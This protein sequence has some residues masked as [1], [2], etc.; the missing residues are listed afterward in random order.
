MFCPRCGTEN[1]SEPSYCRTCGQALSSVR[2]AV[3]GHVDQAIK[4]LRN[5]QRISVYRIRLAVSA[6]LILAALATLFTGGRVGFANIGSATVLLIII[7]IFF[8]QLVLKSRRVARLLDP[9]AERGELGTSPV[10][11]SLSEARTNA[12]PAPVHK[13]PLSVAESTTLKLKPEDSQKH[14]HR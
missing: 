2:L 7:L 12:L 6:F 10:A 13:T 4:V 3:E 1:D 14:N 9:E 5:E 8:V 11:T